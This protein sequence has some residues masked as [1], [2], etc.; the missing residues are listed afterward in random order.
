MMVRLSEAEDDA[1]LDAGQQVEERVGS[2]DYD[3]WACPV[4]P[5]RLVIPYRRWSSYEACPRC[6]YRTVKRETVTLRAA[7][8]AS[9]GL[10]EI[11][12][13]CANPAC[14][15][16]EVT[17][18]VLPQLPVPVPSSDSSGGGSSGGSSDGGSSFGGSG[19]TSGGGGG[20]SY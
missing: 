20:D 8:V 10:E 3:V 5:E 9:A 16:R 12:L 4:C 17:R 14:N 15:W 1:A 19:A 18:R 2:V 6:G 11:R 7:T 13:A